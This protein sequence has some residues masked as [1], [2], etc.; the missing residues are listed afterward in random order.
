MCPEGVLGRCPGVM[1]EF[2]IVISSTG[3]FIISTLATDCCKVCPFR[4]CYSGR[5]YVKFC[6]FWASMLWPSAHV[7]RHLPALDA[8]L[9]VFTQKQRFIQVSRFKALSRVGTPVLETR[10]TSA[11]MWQ[12]RNCTFLH[13]VQRSLSLLRNIVQVEFEY[14]CCDFGVPCDCGQRST[15]SVERIPPD[16]AIH[17]QKWPRKTT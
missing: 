7:A 8:A 12:W 17:E 9:F 14:V 5:M 4:W 10:R 16:T 15:A 6:L 13:P 2:H 3:N 11:S 1:S